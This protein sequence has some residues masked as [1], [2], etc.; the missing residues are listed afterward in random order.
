[1]FSQYDITVTFLF[2]SLWITTTQLISSLTKKKKLAAWCHVIIE[3][4]L[5][6]LLK[7][8]TWQIKIRGQWSSW[9]GCCLSP[10]PLLS[11]RK[12]GHAESRSDTL[13]TEQRKSKSQN[14]PTPRAGI[15]RTPG[16][17]PPGLLEAVVSGIAGLCRS[18][19]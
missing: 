13:D 5:T 14:L 8:F 1:M 12:T 9:P 10:E 7:D 3:N 6:T 15:A 4:S 16:P 2:M 19:P 17:E 18:A 11:H